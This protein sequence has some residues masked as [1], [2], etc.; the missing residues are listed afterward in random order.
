MMMIVIIM[1]ASYTNDDDLHSIIASNTNA[2]HTNAS[3]IMMMIA[4]Y[5]NDDDHIVH[6]S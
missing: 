1:I 6:K 3:Y 4:S 2:S 5:T